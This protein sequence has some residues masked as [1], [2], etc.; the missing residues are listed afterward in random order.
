MDRGAWRAT[1]HGVTKSRSDKTEPLSTA[2]HS[3]APDTKLCSWNII[4]ILHYSYKDG[5]KREQEEGRRGGD[6]EQEEEEEERKKKR[7]GRQEE[8]NRENEKRERKGERGE[9]ARQQE[10]RFRLF[11]HPSEMMEERLEEDLSECVTA[12]KREMLLKRGRPARKLGK[13]SSR[14]IDDVPMTVHTSCHLLKKHT[15]RNLRALLCV[16]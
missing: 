16:I 6:G 12:R 2:Q 15:L 9:E 1:V 8:R 14:I 5:G 11:L 3:T 10:G 13:L 7:D 4:V